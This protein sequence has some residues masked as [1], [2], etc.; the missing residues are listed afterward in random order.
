MNGEDERIDYQAVVD[1]TPALIFSARPD[2]YID[3]FNRRWL[4]Y[5]DG[6]PLDALLG[7]GWT[8]FI[9]PDDVQEHARLWR[10]AM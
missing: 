2:G 4:E 8:K 3:Y 10:E 1:S 5:L 6:V 9:H 7:W